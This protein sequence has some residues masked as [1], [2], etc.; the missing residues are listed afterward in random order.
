MLLERLFA[1]LALN[2]DPFATCG[3]A[4]GWRLQLPCRD[5]VTFHFTLRGTGA[6][7]LGSGKTL[8]LAPGHIAVMPPRVAHAIECGGEIHDE[9]GVEGQASGGEPICAL[10]AGPSEEVAL[11]VACGRIQATYGGTVGLFDRL[12]EA[13]VLDFSDS[14]TMRSTIESL[15]RE[16]GSSDPGSHAMTSA[17]MN[18]CLILTFRRLS[19]LHGGQLPWLSGLDDPQLAKAMDA[20][21][22]HPE[23]PHSVESLALLAHMSR[24]VFARKYSDSFGRPPMDH[25]REVRLR[26]GARLLREHDYTV[27]AVAHKVGF[28][29]RSHFSHA[30]RDLFECAPAEYRRSGVS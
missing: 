18:Q 24:A 2:I 9:A 11:E 12:E 16:Y 26:N 19:E 22:E 3:V 30:F 6:L 14:P 8:H 17:L 10:V 29:S 15:V 5:W 20:I 4:P 27:D 25:L 23:Q 28:A 7:R 1:N 13:F 21:L